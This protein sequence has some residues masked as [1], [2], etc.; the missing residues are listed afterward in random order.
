MK[1]T[2]LV[3]VVELVSI[4]SAFK[5]M[6]YFLTG[7]VFLA[8][9]F[10]GCDTYTQDTYE[11]KYVVQGYLYALEPL[12]S[13]SLSTTVPISQKYDLRDVAVSD[14][15]V[16]VQLLD[17][18]GQVEK[19]FAYVADPDSM[20]MYRPLD[21][22]TRVLPNRTYQLRVSFPNKSDLITAK[23]T[24]PDT[25]T[26]LNT[27][28]RSFTYQGQQAF[29]QTLTPSYN[30]KRQ[31]YFVFTVEGLERKKDNLVPFWHPDT[32]TFDDVAPPDVYA[33][34]IINEANY[35]DPKTGNTIVQLPWVTIVYYGKNRVATN[36]LDDAIYDFFQSQSIQQGGSTLSPNE[37]PNAK[38][39]VLGG[40]G[41]FGSLARVYSEIEV[42][43]K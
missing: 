6:R 30:P 8:S 18:A 37:I 25:M 10:A 15:K 20:S 21:T 13:I 19:T 2:A 36:V 43:R 29:E 35:K 24:I 28:G 33:S 26:V 39:N 32:A 16:E 11:K 40:T 1:Q 23:T 12:T 4:S 3:G 34:P 38:T 41:V 7:F 17:A 31:S 22:Q 14:A 27:N 9:F 42:A 5:I